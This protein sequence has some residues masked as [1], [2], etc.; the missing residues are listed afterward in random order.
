MNEDF[1]NS[2]NEE[3]AQR[4]KWDALMSDWG[5]DKTAILIGILGIVLGVGMYFFVSAN[6]ALLAAG[7]GL[8][9]LIVGGAM[10]ADEHSSVLGTWSAV[11]LTI[12][13]L[14]V[15]WQGPDYFVSLSSVTI[16]IVGAVFIA[17]LWVARSVGNRV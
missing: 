17:S 6:M 14:V 15:M 1:L 9:I 12:I 2:G 4:S 13:T 3:N 16:W 7:V 5:M 11:I 8:S 10:S